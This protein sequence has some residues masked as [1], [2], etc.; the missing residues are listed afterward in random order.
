MFKNGKLGLAICQDW[1]A[2]MFLLN[3][4]VRRRSMT[5]QS[6]Q[7]TVHP[8]TPQKHDEGVAN[9]AAQKAF[10]QAGDYQFPPLE[11]GDRLSRAEFE[12]RYLARPDIKKAELIEGVVYVSSPVRIEQHSEPHATI[13]F[14][15]GYYRATTPGLRMADNGTLRLDVDNEPQPDVCL[16]I[17]EQAGGQAWVNQNDYLEGAPELIVEV[18]GSTAAYDLHDKLNAYRRS[19]VKEYLVLLPNEQKLIWH[20]W[21][22]GEYHT[23]APDEQGILRS[24]VF[25]GLWFHPTR[26]WSGDMAGLLA[27]LQEGINS[28]EHRAFVEQLAS[29]RKID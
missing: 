27:L 23:L 17:D 13:I 28:P 6:A 24:Q 15:L 21:H 1:C 25:P 22:E 3:M 14:W 2:I 11:S 10:T 7:T 26:F 29:Q 20:V 16:W 18:A 9:G 8:S 19:G 4:K 5:V 12:R